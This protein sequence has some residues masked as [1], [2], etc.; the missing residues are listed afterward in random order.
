M[1]A[2]IN[3]S[4]QAWAGWMPV[5][6]TLDTLP[7]SRINRADTP[8]VS[9]IP[10]LLRRR[11]NGLGRAS[12]APAMK[13]LEGSGNA[14]VVYSCRHGDLERS[15]AVLQELASDVPVSPMQ[16]SLSVHNAIAGILSIDRQLT[17]CISSIA[18]GDEGLV[19]T[20]LEAVG[21]LSDQY[22][23]VLCIVS[24]VP[25]PDI[26]RAQGYGPRLPHAA[27]FV[28]SSGGGLSLSVAGKSAGEAA[29]AL[30][31]AMALL[32]FLESETHRLAIN[33]NGSVWLLSKS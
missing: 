26:Y 24:D 3:F 7:G 11:L 1:G 13:V 16:F 27:C 23:Q 20:L 5:D 29:P 28:V 10:A 30:P 14:A 2:A 19:P 31:Q 18:F 22:P 15:L 33:H 17:A 6:P 25:P 9:T 8:D 21:L 4:I 12:V 32:Q